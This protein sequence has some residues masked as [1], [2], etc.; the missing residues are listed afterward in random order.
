M[1][2]LYEKRGGR[3]VE[4]PDL[5]AL[6]LFDMH[7]LII[8]ATRYYTGRTTIPAGCF[9]QYELA[10]AWP[11][12]LPGTKTVIRRDLEREFERDDEARAKGE[13]YLPLGADCDRA[14]WEAVRR[15]WQQEDAYPLLKPEQKT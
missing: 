6:A 5:A 11:L 3:Y 9:A 13:K 12:L 7:G 4:R 14:A 15:A 1:T 8:G 10:R 2:T